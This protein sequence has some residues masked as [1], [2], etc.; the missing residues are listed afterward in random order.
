MSSFKPTFNQSGRS[1]VEVMIALTIGLVILV[2]ITSLFSSSKQ[3]ARATDDKG[4]LEEDGRLALNLLAFHLRMAGY[5]ELT[6]PSV[7]AVN[8]TNL[9]SSSSASTQMDGIEGCSGGFS[10]P[11]TVTRGCV[12]TPPATAADGV[13]VRYVVDQANANTT[14][15]GLPADCLGAAII[16]SPQVVENR[17]YVAISPTTGMSELYCQ[18]S[19]QTLAGALTF[20]NV[21]QPIAE[22]IQDLKITYGF[23]YDYVNAVDTQTVD[24]YISASQVDTMPLPGSGSQ[25]SKVISVKICIVARS[26]NDGV[27]TASQKYRDCAGSIVTP[28]DR[29]LYQTFSTVVALRSRA[30]GSL[31]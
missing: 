9:M 7:I 17:F 29:R 8:N 20:T 2:S 6:N 30:A 16:R 12:S 18:G 19:G 13:L 21:A 24:R 28:S 3:S 11:A 15:G 25:W 31:N 1:L 27:A 26:A 10:S 14:S 23:G 4:R 5:G 22:N